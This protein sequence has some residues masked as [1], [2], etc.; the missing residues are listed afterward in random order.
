MNPD[1]NNAAI[2]VAIVKV[3]NLIIAVKRIYIDTYTTH[4]LSLKG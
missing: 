4:A 1:G 2:R 3:G